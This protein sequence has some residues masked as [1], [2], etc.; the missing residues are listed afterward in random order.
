MKMKAAV[1]REPK[2]ITIEE[3][4]LAPPKENE[5]LVKTHYC[6]YCHSDFS[7]VESG[8]L[9]PI[10]FVTGHEASG[11]VVD[12]GPGVKR[13]KKGDHVVA[14]WAVSCGRC[15]QCVKGNEYIC[16]EYRNFIEAGSL[17]DGT[18][19]LTDANGKP[20]YHSV[21]V[22][23]FAEYLVIPESGAI[24]LREDFPL[25]QAALLGCCVPTGLGAVINTANV[26][27]GDSVAVWGI[28]GIGLNVLQGAKLAGAKPIIA[29]DIEGSKEA[30]AKEFGATHFIDSS[31]QDPIPIVQELSGGGVDYAFEASGDVG[32]IEQIYWALGI[33]G[34]QIQ[35]GLQDASKKAQLQI[36]FTPLHAKDIIGV[37]YGHVHV[38][39]DIP[40]FA[41]LVMDKRYIDLDKLITKKFKLE[42]LQSVHDAMREHK[43]H[44]RWVCE[45]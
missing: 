20:L 10:P 45:F 37:M 4:N 38:H 28:G 34:K 17:L 42:E 6:G 35:I 33:G 5:V 40:A 1:V 32:A 25:D 27:P 12:V 30:I 3:V 14:C 16:P 7:A 21:F 23:G 9:F 31:K 11:V 13:I 15:K 44:G 18:S 29:V 26:K 41:D 24:K 8:Q 19:R 39:T 43:I 22:S 36:I 2:V